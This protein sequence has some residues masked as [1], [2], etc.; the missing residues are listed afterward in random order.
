MPCDACLEDKEYCEVKGAILKWIAPF[1]IAK[2]TIEF[3][4]YR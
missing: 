4:S 1:F 3:H 2:E